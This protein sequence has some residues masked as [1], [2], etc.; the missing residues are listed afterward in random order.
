[1]RLNRGAGLALA[2]PL[3]LGACASP[4]M[5]PGGPP[6][7]VA[8]EVVDVSPDS[9]ATGVRASSV[10]FRFSEVV[11]EAPRVQGAGSG[12]GLGAVVIVSP[13]DGTERVRWHRNEIEIEPRDGFRAGTA[14]RVTLL[15]GIVDLRGNV[16]TESRDLV[17]STGASIPAGAIAGV[18]FDWV[19]GRPAPNARVE[20]FLP[21]D[22]TFRWMTRADSSGRYRLRDLAPGAYTLRA[23]IDENAN[24]QLD[25]RE[26]FDSTVAVLEQAA[27]AADAAHEV[28]LY[29]FVHDTI[30]PRIETVVASDTSVLRVRFNNAVAAGW[31]PTEGAFVLLRTDADSAVVP[32]GAAV[33]ATQ[34]DSVMTAARMLADSIA[35]DSAARANPADTAAARR[36]ADLIERSRQAVATDTV[37]DTLAVP[38]PT[39]QR[40]TP[41]RD[42]AVRLAAPLAPGAYLFRA[43]EIPGLSGARETSERAFTI[44]APEPPDIPNP[45]GR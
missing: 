39:P 10:R 11:S 25:R 1:M 20:A 33:P 18:V 32:L 14:Y 23:F 43:V 19:D 24:R 4:G 9:G 34:F 12:I 44:A 21:P 37:T 22:S 8:P 15:P 17:F 42:W 31:T 3:A 35:I 5:P 40:P 27:G 29:A 16:M 2:V 6:D 7:A 36:L 13:G 30:G 41:S 38:P 26:A 45:P 28:D